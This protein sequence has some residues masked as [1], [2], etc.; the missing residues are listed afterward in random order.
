MT[1]VSKYPRVVSSDIVA[2]C[3]KWERAKSLL[4]EPSRGTPDLKLK[5]RTIA[6][7]YAGKVPACT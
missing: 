4:G 5:L 6:L 3:M 2:V 7:G 1:A